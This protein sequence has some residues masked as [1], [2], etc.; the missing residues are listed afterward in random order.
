LDDDGDN[1]TNVDDLCPNSEEGALVS[2]NGCIT[3]IIQ[4]NVEAKEFDD[5]IST[6]TILFIIAGLIFIVALVIIMRKEDEES[7]EDEVEKSTLEP[8]SLNIQQP[9]EPISEHRNEGDAE[10]NPEIVVEQEV[11]EPQENTPETQ[12]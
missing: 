8:V 3:K 2:A 7:S 10:T 11:A 5:G 6:A 4:D 1:V 12:E 9:E